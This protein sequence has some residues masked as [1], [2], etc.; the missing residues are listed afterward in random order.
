MSVRIRFSGRVPI[1]RKRLTGEDDG[2]ADGLWH[3]TVV[4]QDETIERA[5]G[6]EIEL[7]ERFRRRLGIDR[8]ALSGLE[9]DLQLIRRQIRLRPAYT[10]WAS[11]TSS[12]EKLA[13]SARQ[14]PSGD[15]TPSGP[16]GCSA[17]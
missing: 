9:N 6:L 16:A 3:A 17:R 12:T 14:V 13:A 7:R 11:P 15:G 10:Y 5:F 8:L 1:E 4:E 2:L